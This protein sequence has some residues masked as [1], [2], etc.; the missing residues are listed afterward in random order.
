MQLYFVIKD[1]KLLKPNHQ[2]NVIFL[3]YIYEVAYVLHHT[4]INILSDIWKVN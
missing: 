1:S 2:S 3:E 4:S